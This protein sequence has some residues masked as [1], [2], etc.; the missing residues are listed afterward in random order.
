VTRHALLILIL[1]TASPA[2]E[3]GE[4]DRIGEARAAATEL[5]QK[6]GA[7]LRQELAVSGPDGAITICRE[8]APSLA[9]ELS[10]RTGWRIARVSLRARNPLLGAPDAWEQAVLQRFDR[11]V[12]AGEPPDRLEH[13][14]TVLEPHGRYLRYMKALPVQPLCLTCHGSAEAVPESVRQRL[15]REYPHDHAVG[16]DTGQLRGAVT[17][18][19]PLDPEP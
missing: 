5:V 15:A 6:L 18:K 7:A 11:A 12:A 1:C 16:Y 10:R 2:L 4:D 13:S 19:V 8:T 9:S 14:E 17:V 3:A